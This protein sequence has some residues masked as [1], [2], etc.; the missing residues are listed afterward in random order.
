MYE[1]M[2]F[3]ILTHTHTLIVSILN[4]KNDSK[5]LEASNCQNVIQGE[6]GESAGVN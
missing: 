3:K 6:I 4:F 2:R 1:Q 5:F